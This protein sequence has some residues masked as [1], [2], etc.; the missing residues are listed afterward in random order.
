VGIFIP[1]Y[2]VDNRFCRIKSTLKCSMHCC[3][4]L[5]LGF[6]FGI[7]HQQHQREPNNF[8][9]QLSILSFQQAEQTPALDLRYFI[10]E[11]AH[12]V[13]ALNFQEE[14]DL[15]YIDL[16]PST[17]GKKGITGLKFNRDGKKTMHPKIYDH[18]ALIDISSVCAASIYKH[19]KE[20]IGIEKSNFPADAAMMVTE[21]C[22]EDYERFGKHL[23]PVSRH[24]LLRP[25]HTQWNTILTAFDFF[26]MDGVWDA[27]T[28][29]AELISENKSIGIISH[30]QMLESLS[31]SKCYPVFC[32][33]MES[34]LMA[35]YPLTKKSLEL[36][37]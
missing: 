35:R 33:A 3:K 4:M 17:E 11:A 29:I 8:N 9:L 37:R 23:L 5:N 18:L 34:F 31:K 1:C 25:L 30:A 7:K 27:V 10:T 20:I 16:N 22:G 15:L 2:T 24:F 32:S 13:M 14:F 36:N 21:G 28:F 19:G 12:Y 6:A 26:L